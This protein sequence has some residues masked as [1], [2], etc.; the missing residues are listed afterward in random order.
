MRNLNIQ[1]VQT[2][3]DHTQEVL[4]YTF[5]HQLHGIL[6][7]NADYIVGLA[8]AGAPRYFSSHDLRL[9]YKETLETK[10]FAVAKLLSSLSLTA[11]HMPFMA[12]LLGGYIRLD[13]TKLRDIYKHIKITATDEA[14]VDTRVRRLAEIIRNSPTNELDA[15]IAHLD[16]YAW[17]AEIKETVLYYQR[18]WKFAAKLLDPQYAQKSKY[19]SSLQVTKI[20]LATAPRPAASAADESKASDVPCA[21]APATTT[22]A[23]PEDDTNLAAPYE[24]ETE[25]NVVTIPAV[26]ATNNKKD[27]GTDQL[28]ELLSKLD[29][30][31]ATT[32]TTSVTVPANKTEKTSKKSSAKAAAAAAKSS[33]TFVYT[34]PSEVLRT[35]FNRHQRGIMDPKIYQLLTRKEIILP[36]ILED[37]TYRDMPSVHLFYR[38][39]RQMIYAILFNVYHQKYL[40]SQRTEEMAAAAAAAAETTTAGGNSKKFSI[41]LN[42][43]VN[44]WIWTPK[45]NYSRPERVVPELLPWA[46]PT[47]QRLW[48][49]TVF[50]DKQRRMKAFLSIMRSDSPLMLNRSHVPQH[51]LTLA[52]VLRYIVTNPE[53]NVLTRP[54]LDAFL[55]TAFSPHIINIEYTQE[56][57]VSKLNGCF[58]CCRNS[59]YDPAPSP[60]LLKK[61]DFFRVWYQT[62]GFLNYL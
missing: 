47:I 59:L 46:V 37:E 41:P 23:T 19:L 5:A 4:E 49:G 7:L 31:V 32:T 27:D 60:Q 11:D 14:A 17:A 26:A 9:S 53:R 56:L 25:A 2:V 33:S 12:T 44:E 10:E 55:A 51:M 28:T 8:Q 42:V 6:G 15:F 58:C 40:Y 20:K 22:T 38:P 29:T 3:H 30:N 1:V 57:V 36:Q 34:L 35:S 39:A 52:C 48:F 54:E 45:N 50:E 16:L 62:I 61:G 43:A 18:K 21:A 13:E 24:V